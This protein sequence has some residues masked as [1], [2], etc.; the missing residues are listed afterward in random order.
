MSLRPILTVGAGNT[1][2]LVEVEAVN[3]GQKHVVPA[4][5]MSVGGSA[6]NHACRLLASG[7][8]ALPLVPIGD[9]DTGATIK[10]LVSHAA[11]RGGLSEGERGRLS[12]WMDSITQVGETSG[13]TTILVEG[14]GRRTIFS[15]TGS[16]TRGFPDV[17]ARALLSIEPAELAAVVIGHIHA[18]AAPGEGLPYGQ[19]GKI[20]S[21]LIAQFRGQVPIVA[22]LGRSQYRLG[23]ER[24]EEELR[25]VR[26]LQLAYAEA[27]EFTSTSPERPV[28]LVA[29][30]RWFRERRIN[31]VITVDRFGAVGVAN[32]SEDA[33]VA[34]PHDL[35]D[36]MVDA[37]GAGDALTAGLAAAVSGREASLGLDVDSL[38]R[39]MEAAQP[40]AAYACTRMGGATDC[41]SE[42]DL[43]RFAAEVTP[44]RPMEKLK[45]DDKNTFL[46]LL[47]RAFLS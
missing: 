14:G 17:C 34:W 13:H 40:W 36:R 22:N 28:G 12:R 30:A 26:L 42:Q 21:G 27:A 39:C 7:Y 38:S 1:E 35:G 25:D 47:D 15:E 33:V 20:T 6:V 41:P 2:S 31:A 10:R 4:V 32:G 16:V 43:R 9:D 23:S 8:P 18:D 46:W 24:W 29:M 45:L 11:A 44:F 5:I 37:T 19:S 3:M